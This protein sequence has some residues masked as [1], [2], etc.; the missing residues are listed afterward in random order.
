M[1]GD[2]RVDVVTCPLCVRGVSVLGTHEA[3]R[4]LDHEQEWSPRWVIRTG[5]WTID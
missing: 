4:D 3:L 2:S 5:E 1:R